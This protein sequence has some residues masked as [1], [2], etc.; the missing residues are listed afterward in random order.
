MLKIFCVSVCL[1]LSICSPDETKMP[2]RLEV[3]TYGWSGAELHVSTSIGDY[4]KD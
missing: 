4:Q 3:N 2:L 1:F